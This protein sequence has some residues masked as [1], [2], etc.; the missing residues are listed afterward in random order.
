MKPTAY[1]VNTARGRIVDE[2]ALCAALANG[3]IAGAALDVFHEE[4]LPTAHPLRKMSNV[5]LTSHLGW[6]TDEMY[7]QSADAAADVLLAYAEGKDVP[8]F[9]AG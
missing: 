8:R 2:V 9:V 5:V 6:P 4:P 3:K 1:L 7:A